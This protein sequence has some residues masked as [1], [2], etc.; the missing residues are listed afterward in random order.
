[1]VA[2]KLATLGQGQRQDRSIDLSTTQDEAAELLNVSVPSLKRA[3]TVYTNGDPI[4]VE[5]APD[6]LCHRVIKQPA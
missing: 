3:R 1:M 4:L 6:R 2:A 5:I